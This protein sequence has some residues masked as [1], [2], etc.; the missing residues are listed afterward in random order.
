MYRE[1]RELSKADAVTA[2]YRD[3]ASRHRVRAHSLHIISVDIVE[4]KDTRRE[5]IK[6]FHVC[7]ALLHSYLLYGQ[8][9][10]GLPW[11]RSS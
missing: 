11:V 4:A 9:T 6:Q 2:C 8:F 7:L 3:M 10:R 1:Y 5:N